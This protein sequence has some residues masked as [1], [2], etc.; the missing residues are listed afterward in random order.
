MLGL[1]PH[2]I[3]F[4]DRT[5]G[6]VDVMDMI[7]GNYT[8]KF[9]TRRWTM[10][11]LAYILNT[12]KTNS[13]TIFR[14]LHP[15]TR[16]SSFEFVWDLAQSLIKSHVVTRQQNPLGLQQPSLAAIKYVLGANEGTSN[17]SFSIPDPNV[18]KKRCHLCLL[19]IRGVLGYKGLK[20]KLAKSQVYLLQMQPERLPEAL[21]PT[22]PSVFRVNR[23]NCPLERE[24]IDLGVQ[25]DCS[26][27]MD[28]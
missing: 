28:I 7:A 22:V 27:P 5:K 21:P 17:A 2:V 20:D 3:A 16:M 23:R 1:K 24:K 14:D 8:T 26:K 4:Y 11:T 6:G 15:N 18:H 25:I 9:K 12:A 19:S 10:N 13:L